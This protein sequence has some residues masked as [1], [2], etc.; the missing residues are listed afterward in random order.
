MNRYR[1]QGT[2]LE[3]SSGQ[4]TLRLEPWGPDAIRVRAALGPVLDGLPGALLDPPDVPDTHVKIED[5]SA[6]LVSGSIT[7]TI[8][9]PYVGCGMPTTTASRT[10]SARACRPKSSSTTWIGQIGR[11]SCR[12]RV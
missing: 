4:E 12:E 10:G 5:G 3:C 9:S 2:A 8:C 7:A 11:A 1:E 6:Q